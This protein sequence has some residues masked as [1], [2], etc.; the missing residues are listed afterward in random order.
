M[1]QITLGDVFSEDQLKQLVKTY[2]E[3]VSQNETAS[4]H[5]RTVLEPLMPQI[6]QRTGQENDLD[7]WSYLLEHTFS[8]LRQE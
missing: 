2:K 4:S 3:A 1:K 5:L 6:N 7:F 8:Q